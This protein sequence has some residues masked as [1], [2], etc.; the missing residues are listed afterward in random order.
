MV[1]LTLIYTTNIYFGFEINAP[2]AFL[3][4]FWDFSFGGHAKKTQSEVPRPSRSI[5]I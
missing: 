1:V 5:G 2:V 3:K 4:E